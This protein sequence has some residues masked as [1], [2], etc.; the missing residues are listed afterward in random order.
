MTPRNALIL[1]ASGTLGG[2]IARELIARG[3]AAGLHYHAHKEPCEA[4]AREAQAKGVKACCYAADFA[5]PAAPGALATAFLKDFPTVDALVWAAGMVRDAPLLTLTEEDLRAVLDV[6]LKAFFLTLKALARQFIKQRTG[7]IVALSSHAALAGRAGGTAYAMAH[8][9][10]LA[11]VK[12]AARELGPVGVRVN[13]VIPPFVPESGMGRTASPEFAAA[14][15]Q[16]RVLKPD[17]DGATA[18]AMFVCD[19]LGNPAISGQVL[20]ADSRIAV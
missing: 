15:R 10:L 11:L 12:S 2:A 17:A 6:D 5:D 14:A 20:S 19:V 3:C 18:L 1:G 16:K 9:G 4:L 8:S 13:A 7:A